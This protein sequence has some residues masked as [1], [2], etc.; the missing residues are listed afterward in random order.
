[1]NGLHISG[2]LTAPQYVNLNN[3]EGYPWYAGEMDRDSATK[4]LDAHENGTFLVRMRPS[5]GGTPV[6]A[7]SIADAVYALSLRYSLN[8]TYS[9]YMENFG[10]VL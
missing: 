3:L 9:Q 2:N 7:N 4:V 1:M 5:T 6:L 10:Q 8:F